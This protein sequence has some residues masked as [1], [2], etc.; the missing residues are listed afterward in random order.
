MH[1]IYLVTLLDGDLHV[2]GAGVVLTC[3]L[4]CGP[5]LHD[6][7]QIS[8][9]QCRHI[10]GIGSTLTESALMPFTLMSKVAYTSPIRILMIL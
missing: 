2:T 8:C 7:I 6:V 1:T 10:G 9:L 4:V 3:K 5:K